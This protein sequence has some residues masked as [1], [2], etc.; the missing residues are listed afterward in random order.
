MDFEVSCY[1]NIYEVCQS[2]VNMIN[3]KGKNS[4]ILTKIL[5]WNKY[6]G[7]AQGTSKHINQVKT[8]H[9]KFRPKTIFPLPIGSGVMQ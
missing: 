1:K 9:R 5:L 6:L 8:R 7:D 3:Q 4:A 2:T